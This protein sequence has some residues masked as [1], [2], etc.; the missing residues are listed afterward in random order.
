MDKQNQSNSA[1]PI[2][3]HQHLP[4]C[5][6]FK[7]TEMGGPGCVCKKLENVKFNK[8]YPWP[9]CNCGQKLVFP[10]IIQY[11]AEVLHNGRVEPFVVPDMPINKCFECGTQLITASGDAKITEC[12]KKHLEKKNEII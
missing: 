2:L 11:K 5:N 6:A 4:Y 9:C 12:F 7:A 3:L 1:D 8:P 10:C